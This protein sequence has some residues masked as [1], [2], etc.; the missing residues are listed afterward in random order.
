MKRIILLSLLAALSLTTEAQK[1]FRL[2]SDTSKNERT[3]VLPILVFTP[4]THLGVGALG[5]RLWKNIDSLHET[6]TSNAELVALY[7]SRQQIILIPRYTIFTRGEKYL[8]EGFGEELIGFRDFYFGQGDEVP[9]TTHNKADYKSKYGV[10]YDVLGWENRIGRRV[11]K[12]HKLFIGLE[13]RAIQYYNIRSEP[14]GVLDVSKVEGYQGSSSIGLG[15]ALTWDNRDNVVNPSKGFYWDT[16][17]SMYSTALGGTVNYHRLFIDLRKYINVKPSKRHILA[18]ELLANFV[19]GDAPFKE[20]AELG[21]PRI[22]RG[23]Y[24]GRFRD[25]YLT[26]VQT[27][28]RIPLNRRIGV[29]GFA[30]VGKVYNP[31]QVNLEGLHYSYGGGLR[32]NIN[33]R[34]KLNLRLD[35]ALGDPDHPGYFYLGFSESF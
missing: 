25:N 16:R 33:K 29:V 6:R 2:W 27:E 19:R 31:S 14:T 10:V 30:G 4:E 32:V 28:Y 12:K 15:P 20:M 24:R 11:F 22:M 8:I 9:I 1:K 3:I 34:E 23:F 18:F 35:Y 21:G 5:I 17:Y 26:A 7:T 13:T